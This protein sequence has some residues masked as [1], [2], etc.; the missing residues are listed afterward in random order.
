MYISFIKQITDN[1]Q[2]TY[3]ANQRSS[4]NFCA[5]SIKNRDQSPYYYFCLQGIVAPLLGVRCQ[6]VNV[7]IGVYR[8]CLI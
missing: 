4:Q 2:R 3:A 6:K 5:V 8:V 1:L 7:V